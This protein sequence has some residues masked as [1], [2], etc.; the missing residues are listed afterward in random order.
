MHAN[1][2]MVIYFTDKYNEYIDAV[3]NVIGVGACGRENTLQR[4]KLETIFRYFLSESD[5]EEGNDCLFLLISDIVGSM[6]IY[7][8]IHHKYTF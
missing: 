2:K 1:G 8:C 5:A 7:T 6:F 4:I 3:N